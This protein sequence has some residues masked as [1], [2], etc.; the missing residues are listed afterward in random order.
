M[1]VV[2]Y[3][4]L[5]DAVVKIPSRGQSPSHRP[6]ADKLT[7][8]YSTPPRRKAQKTVVSFW[9]NCRN[10]MIH[11]T[12]NGICRDKFCQ[13]CANK[14]LKNE[15]KDEAINYYDL[16]SLRTSL[17]RDIDVPTGTRSTGIDSC[18]QSQPETCDC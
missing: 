8:E 18:D 2:A 7:P 17:I 12:F 11:T 10:P 1:T 16:V 13:R 15:H 5:V 9:G 14:T 4:K 3:I 6:F